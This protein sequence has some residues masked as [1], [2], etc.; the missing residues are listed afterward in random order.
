M[1]ANYP[2]NPERRNSSEGR[3]R[4]TAGLYAP[5]GGNTV[6][7]VSAAPEFGDFL[8][9]AAQKQQDNISRRDSESE[10]PR[11]VYSMSPGQKK[12][13]RKK[14]GSA[15]FNRFEI[16]IDSDRIYCSDPTLTEFTR[17]LWEMGMLTP[18][19]AELGAGKR[20]LPR[21]VFI[22]DGK[23]TSGGGLVSAGDDHIYQSSGWI[24]LLYPR[25]IPESVGDYFVHQAIVLNTLRVYL[26]NPAAAI[27][28]WGE[29]FA[30]DPFQIKECLSAVRKI[31]AL[32]EDTAMRDKGALYTKK[33]TF[34]RG[35]AEDEGIGGI[36]DTKLPVRKEEEYDAGMRRNVPRSTAENRSKPSVNIPRE[37]IPRKETAANDIGETRSTPP[38]P[39]G[40][41]GF[42]QISWGNENNINN[43]F[44]EISWDSE[45]KAADRNG[46]RDVRRENPGSPKGE[47]RPPRPP[48]S[49]LSPQS[50]RS[51]QPS[52]PVQSP[53]SSQSLQSSQSS[54]SNRVSGERQSSV[55]DFSPDPGTANIS[56][57]VSGRDMTARGGMPAGGIS[58]D[59]PPANKHMPSGSIPFEQPPESGAFREVSLDEAA[60]TAA[61]ETAAPENKI[62]FKE[63]PRDPIVHKGAA[64][65]AKAYREI[66]GERSGRIEPVPDSYREPPRNDKSRPSKEPL[67]PPR[68]ETPQSQQS[69]DRPARRETSTV[70]AY[71]E[72][73]KERNAKRKGDK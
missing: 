7:T 15:R 35:R 37:N 24:D 42:E 12:S 39:Q 9:A 28:L 1:P 13:L 32:W 16:V 14:Y 41:S 60:G 61:P 3:E 26:S 50:S 48:R 31:S 52:Q 73:F 53:R 64:G 72:M 25:R 34:Y 6:K 19:E 71:Q 10:K 59:S 45:P 67:K 55:T 54:R 36:I 22:A 8:N 65:S 63:I 66:P 20:P 30:F 43:T 23:G 40:E 33:R 21:D 5:A 2:E 47:V 11:R 4:N 51:V 62:P 58:T 56:G 69:S 17:K 44:E 27:A 68:R 46:G 49:T 18:E 38:A 70:A 57:A 29:Y